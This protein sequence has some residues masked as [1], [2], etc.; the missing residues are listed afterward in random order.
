M[1]GNSKLEPGQELRDDVL[2]GF[3][4]RAHRSGYVWLLTYRLPTGARR[5]LERGT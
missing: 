3:G 1:G 5:R 2:P 4:V